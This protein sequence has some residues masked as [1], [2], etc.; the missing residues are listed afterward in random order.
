[1]NEL[2][3]NIVVEDDVHE[4][5]LFRIFQYVNPDIRI[6]NVHGK[7]GNDYIKKNIFSFNKAAV[8]TPHIILTDLDDIACPVELINQWIDF[9]KDSSFLFRIAVTEG[10]T[11]LLSD[12]TNFS[13]YIGVSP[14]NIKHDPESIN[15]PKAFIINLIRKKSKKRK[16]REDIIPTGSSR[17]GPGYNTCLVEFIYNKWDIGIARKNSNSLERLIVRMKEL[18]ERH[19][20]HS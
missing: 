6:A 18:Y 1:M 19:T 5:L 3:V 20:T 13:K 9:Q 10:E 14:T 2:Y 17:I 4:A 16:I 11:W 12:P 8:I 7:R 15:D